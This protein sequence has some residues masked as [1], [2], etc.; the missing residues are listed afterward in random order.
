MA[1]GTNSARAGTVWT[2]FSLLL[3]HY[4]RDLF[5]GG[6]LARICGRGSNTTTA[7]CW[8]CVPPLSSSRFSA[9]RRIVP[10]CQAYAAALRTLARSIVFCRANVP[11]ISYISTLPCGLRSLFCCRGGRFVRWRAKRAWTR[12]TLLFYAG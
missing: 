8:H 2:A 7:F 5:F 1:A 4:R 10:K 3:R 12:T 6:A 9:W 11:G